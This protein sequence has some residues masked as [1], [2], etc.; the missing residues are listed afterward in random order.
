MEGSKT[1][2]NSTMQVSF[3]CQRCS[4][5]L[6]LDTSFKILDRVTIQELTAPLLTT[7][8]AKPGETQEEETNSGEVE[9]ASLLPH[10]ARGRGAICRMMS[11]ESANSFTLIGEASDGGTMENLSRRLKASRP[12]SS[13]KQ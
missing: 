5:P 11:T 10:V 7:A 2:N 12:R 8:Q 4:Q 1:S 3:V 6:K 13:G 9:E